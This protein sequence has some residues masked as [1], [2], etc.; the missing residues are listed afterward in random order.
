MES[1]RLTVRIDHAYEI[2]CPWRVCQPSMEALHM[3]THFW[4]V[5]Q[6]LEHEFKELTNVIALTDAHLDVYSIVMAD[7]LL[8]LGSEAENVAKAIL[9]EHTGLFAPAPDLTHLSRWNFPKLGSFLNQDAFAMHT[10]TV[11]I[12]WIHSTLSEVHKTI[13]PMESWAPPRPV[14]PDWY[15]AYNTI[16]HNRVSNFSNAAYRHCYEGLAAILILNIALRYRI[17]YPID[18]LSDR[19]F[20]RIAELSDVFDVSD[21]IKLLPIK[22]AIT[23][24]QEVRYVP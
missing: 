12:Q 20:E 5:Y 18:P 21:V 17:F 15:L 24:Q 2:A 19:V 6:R 3:W 9:K 13:K 7:L 23:L 1:C 16:K 10:K 8:R 22:D 11:K 14:N 4:P